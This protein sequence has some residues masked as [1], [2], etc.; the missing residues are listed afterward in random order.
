MSP[1][2]ILAFLYGPAAL[3]RRGIKGKREFALI[4]DDS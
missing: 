1:S 2:G 4:S 3:E